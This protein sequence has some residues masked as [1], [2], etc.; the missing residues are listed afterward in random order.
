MDQSRGM[1][2]RKRNVVYVLDSSVP[3]L[4]WNGVQNDL[5]KYHYTVIHGEITP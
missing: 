4:K 1:N 2:K 3:N 5:H